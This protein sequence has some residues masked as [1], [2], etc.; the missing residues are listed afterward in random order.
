[1]PTSG[2]GLVAVGG[3]LV[4]VD[5]K[6][7]TQAS[8]D[9][10]TS[11]LLGWVVATKAGVSPSLGAI[12]VDMAKVGWSIAATDE[13]TSTVPLSSL[14]DELWPAAA[15][16][17]AQRAALGALDPE[18]SVSRGW[19]KA[20]V[21]WDAANAP[22]LTLA[23]VEAVDRAT[24]LYVATSQAE[25]PV[26]DLYLDTPKTVKVHQG[27]QVLILDADVYAGIRTDVEAKVAKYQGLVIGP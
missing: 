19:W 10:I 25:V 20:S 3:I 17:D 8:E 21:A 6:V 27:R 22:P 5:P 13:V 26:P 15:V 1:M 14:S 18:S 23:R 24:T 12:T 9:A 16:S 2:T 4:F 11:L 7:P